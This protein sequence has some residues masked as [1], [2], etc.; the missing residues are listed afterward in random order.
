MA[1]VIENVIDLTTYAQNPEPKKVNQLSIIHEASDG[2]LVQYFIDPENETEGDKKTYAIGVYDKDTRRYSY[3][4]Y[5]E[6]IWGETDQRICGNRIERLGV[7]AFPDVG[8][9]AFY[10]LMHR[11]ITRIVAP[12]NPKNKQNTA[13]SLSAVVNADNTVTFT[14]TPPEKPKYACYRIVMTSGIYEEDFI[15][16]ET[17]KTCGPVRVSGTYKCF[18]IGY[19]KEGQL[20]SRDSNVL[21]LTLTGK[22]STFIRPYFMKSEIQAMQDEHKIIRESHSVSVWTVLASPALFTHSATV[23]LTKTPGT[24]SVIEL[25]ND[26]LALFAEHGFSIQSVAGNTVTIYSIGAPTDE[27]TLSFLLYE[28]VG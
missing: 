13:P 3:N 1:L 2:E 19:G 23:T 14:I 16:Y 27:V 20:L 5:D 24:T 26:N 15:T 17:V 25:V 7:K 18:A 11:N 21:T 6:V 12:V 8:A 22:S 9:I 10:K 28:V 4:D